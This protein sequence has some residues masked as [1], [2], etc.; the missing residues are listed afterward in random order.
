MKKILTNLFAKLAM[1]AVL[2][3]AFA[4]SAWG[5]V[6]SGTTYSTPSVN[7]LPSGWS[8]NDGGGTSYIKLT[9]ADNYIQTASF[10]QNGFS[11]IKLKAR[12]FGGPSDAQALITV[13][14]YSNN[15][16]TVLG[17]IA[18]T[19]TSLNEYTISK[20]TNPTGNT[21]GYVKIQ[22]KGASSSKGSGV[23]EVTINFTAVS[24]TTYTVSYNANGGTGTMT[25]SNSPY[26]AG[27]SVTVLDNTFTKDG[28]S[29]DKWNTA[30]NGSGTDYD[31]GDTF[32]INANTTLYAQ[33][34]DDNTGGSSVVLTQSNLE[35]TGS[36][37]SNASKT[38]GGITFVHTDLM[39]SNNNIQAKASSGTIKN[40]TAF[41]GD[42]TSVSIT[43]SGTARATTINGSADGTNWVQV[44]TGNGS[45]TADFSS[46]GY[47]YFQITRGS[48]AAYWEKI[49]ITYSESSSSLSN[50]DLAISNA[51]TDLAFD[52]YNNAAAQVIT[53]STSSTG[54]ITITPAS[55]TSYFSYVHDASAKTITVTPLAVTTSAQT[56][57]ISQAA[58]DS[59]YAGTATFTVSVADSDPNK[60]G[61]EN[62]PYTVA[63]ARAAI[64][65]GA[66]IQGVY[67]TGIVSQIVTAY[68]SG[69]QNV[70]FDIVD[71][72]G[73]EAYLRAY[74]CGGDDAENVKVGDIVVVYGNLTKYNSTYEFSQGCTISSLTPTTVPHIQASDV[75][76]EYNATSGE[77][78]YTVDNPSTGVILGATTTADWISNIE[79]T[80]DKVTFTTTPNDG[81]AN[82][83]A[84]VILTYAGA[85]DKTVTVTQ[86]HYVIDY[87]S[88]PFSFDGGHSDIDNTAGLTQNGLGTSDYTSSPKLKFDSAND[89]VILKINEAPGVLSFD[90]K[91]NPSQG[92][93]SGT[94]KVQGS[95]DGVTYTDIQTYSSMSSSKQS[96][97]IEQMGSDVRYIKWILVTKDNGNV[98]LGNINLAKVDLTP[99]ITVSSSAINAPA[100]ETEGTLNVSYKNIDFTNAPEVFFCTSEGNATTYDWIVASVNSENNVDYLIEANT[101]AARTAYFKV[102]GLDSEAN[103]VYSELVTVSQNEPNYA[104]LPFEWDDTTTPKGITNS[105]VGTYSSSPHLKFDDTGD[106]IILEF[107]ETPGT[108]TFD[109]KG[110]GFS[111][112]TFKVQ[113][114]SDGVSYTDLATYTA[115]SDTQNEEFNLRPSVRFIK[116][117]YVEK[118]SG[119]VGL[120]NIKLTALAAGAD[121]YTLE[122]KPSGG[123]Y[124][125]SFYCSSAG[126]TLSDG[127]KAFTLNSNKQLYQLG[128][129][130]VIPA[131]T[132]VVIISDTDLIT[133]RESTRASASV[134]GGDNI[135][136]GADS[137]KAV[138]SITGT[139]YVLGIVGDALGF[140]KYTGDKVPAMKAYYIVNQ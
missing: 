133:L 89:C 29:F 82:R 74:R 93:W 47:K 71:N 94:F 111:G 138:S 73:D 81:D 5:Q 2:A 115:L 12:K 3:T 120:G 24:G 139:P 137:A 25:D 108:L 121:S 91:G 22:C 62:A 79:V 128:D 87:A 52:L 8:G 99:S 75:E 107:N 90:I 134:S 122:G 41:P 15:T 6:V 45:I 1:V 40:T 59:Y 88:L 123:L 31:E 32:T 30:A 55:P 98:A 11:S 26:S 110:N 124:W 103:D 58:D 48:N 84:T 23:S 129:G 130:N 51:S 49:E 68:D 118:V 136:V 42:I 76:L 43:H 131:N 112:G 35:L 86:K 54:A 39:K 97:T 21:E 61:S 117:V 27:A 57:T 96:E 119:N 16:E 95:S 69:F 64:D 63:Q 83:T 7:S 67:A 28:F 126:Y 72:S 66:G 104:T 33:W 132:A 78:A 140:Y 18:P 105:G 77:I 109:I 38:I 19:N 17:T 101:G 4:G 20:P 100:T 13:S 60:P 114:S 135:L 37:S 10:S 44:A 70:T 34:T 127:A 53:Y 36:Y 65:A 56:V 46:K 85:A 116:W 113:T 50:S 80:A 9:A 106:F 102:Y 125:A 14:W 92:S